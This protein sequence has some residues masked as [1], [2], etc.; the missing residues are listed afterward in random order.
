MH[1]RAIAALLLL[2]SPAVAAEDV[3]RLQEAALK[4]SGA[5]EILESLTTEVGPRLVGSAN[6][7][8]AVAW[9]LAKLKALGFENVHS[10]PFTA[11]KWIR[12]VETAE[13]VSPFPQT[14]KVTALGTSVATSTEGIQAEAVLFSSYAALLRAP[15]GSLTGKI[16]VVTEPLV[17]VEDGAGYGVAGKIRRSGASEAAKRGAVAFLLRSL[18]SDHHRLPHTGAQA[19]IDGVMKIPAGA[20][21]VPDAELLDRMAKRGQPIR[22]RLTL[23]PQNLGPVISHTVVG[24]IR[25]SSKPD[26]IIAIG[27]HLDSWDL[28]TGAIDDGAGVAI[29]TAA[30][31]LIHDQGLKPQRTIRVILYGAEEP[32]LVGAKAY[33]QAHVADLARYQ[34][35]FESDFGAGRIYGL[36]TKFGTGAKAFA[37]ILADALQP[38][39]IIPL[40]GDAEGG[41]DG[42][43][44]AKAG[45]PALDLAQDGTHYF[46]IHHTAD[47]TLDKVDPA[48]LN[49][50]V[51]AFATAAWLA[52][53]TQFNL[54][55][56]TTK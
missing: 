42:G 25:G 18:G 2:T 23:T 3:S 30:A 19:Y 52:A 12:G 43:E 8:R 44:L 28:G 32:G 35:V 9:A 29:A 51:A 40:K 31:K 26:E 53:N 7:D 54:R 39:A 6:D 33:V 46:D 11:Q 1:L 48:D 34:L 47:D 38:L 14:L 4:G 36:Q 20:L 17:R 10:E 15:M 49:Q 50:N 21:S 16:A 45:V 24:D 55:D 5:Y 22:L 41:P 27:G 37:D 56:V 13:I